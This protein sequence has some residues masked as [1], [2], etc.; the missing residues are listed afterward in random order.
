MLENPNDPVT[1]FERY[2]YFV[3]N[4]TYDPNKVEKRKTPADSKHY[5]KYV[6]E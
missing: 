2:S 1:E 5:E 3:K 4:H 6:E